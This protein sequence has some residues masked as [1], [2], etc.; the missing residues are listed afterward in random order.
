MEKSLQTLF[1]NYDGLVLG[2]NDFLYTKDLASHPMAYFIY[3]YG[4][5]LQSCGVD[6]IYLENH[7]IY[8]PLQTRGLIG[9]VMYCS[10]LFNFRVIG[11]EAKFTPEMYKQHTGKTIDE[12]W[13]TVAFSTKR[14]VERLNLITKDIVEYSKQG[15]YLVF[16]GMSHVNDEMDVTSCKGIKT[17]L[18]IPGVGCSFSDQTALT[19]NKPFRDPHSSYERP[20]D[21]ML[22]LKSEETSNDRLYIDA[23]IWCFIHDHLFFYKTVYHL[24]KQYN[25]KISVHTLW[26]DTATI[27]PPLYRM[28]VDDMIQRDER[29]RLPE[30]ELNELCAYLH[31]AILGKKVASRNRINEAFAS[32]TDNDMDDIVDAWT[33]WVKKLVRRQRTELEPIALNAISD[34]IFLEYKSLSTDKEEHRYLKYLKNKY[35]KQLERPEHKI[36]TVMRIMKSLHITYPKHNLIEKILY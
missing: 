19:P 31:H 24:G 28:Y 4:R 5:L 15:K 2:G 17:L 14:R 18:G 35:R 32:F 29:L 34:L 33:D 36:Y 7:Y 10:Y 1:E 13:T 22:E 30:K 12:T 9:H 27:F 25:K 11:I 26:N 21:Y 8:E 23:S 6:T 3:E 20:S 16:C